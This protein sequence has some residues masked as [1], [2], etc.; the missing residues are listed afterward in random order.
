MG[1]VFFFSNPQPGHYYDYTFRV[2]EALLNGSLGL[3]TQPPSYLNEFVPVE[4]VWYSVFPLGSVVTMIPFALLRAVG[5][6]AAMPGAGLAGL[7]AAT[8]FYLMAMMGGEYDLPISRVLLIAFG[9]LFGTWT[10]VNLTFAG[11]WQLALGIAMAGE[12]GAIYFTVYDKRPLLAGA[13]FALAFGNRTEVLLTAPV[14][15]YLLVRADVDDE[16][17]SQAT[18]AGK[19]PAF[20]RIA[21]FC[22]VPFVIGA[23]TLWYNQTRFGSPFDFGYARIPGV[24]DEPWYRHGIFS[25]YYIPRQAWEMLLKP[26]RFSP[27]FPYLV[28]DGFSSSI[29]ISS[30]FLLFAFRR[31]ARDRLLKWCAWVAIL[32]MTVLLWTHGNSG[33]WQF[34]YRYWMVCLPWMYVILLETAPKRISRLEWGVYVFSFAVNAYAVWLFHWTSYLRP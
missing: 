2:A 12:L 31:G 14:L 16:G 28:P 25:A 34:G 8:I 26:W 20:R 15:M 13:F 23:A 33:G 17:A 21:Y 32:L 24:L 10:W 1:V 11:A 4:G 27:S 7:L 22:V 5:V 3:S 29:L 6:I 19:V 9:V 30:P 18:L